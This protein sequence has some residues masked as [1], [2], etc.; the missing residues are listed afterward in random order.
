MTKWEKVVTLHRLLGRSRYSVPL[1]TILAELDNCSE[2]TFHRI[3]D[4]MRSNL[5]APLE[6]DRAHGGYRYTP[7]D[8]GP[9]ELPGFWL[10]KD[11]IEAFIC[12]DNA[13]ENL[14]EG[15]FSDLLAPLRK[16][17]EPLIRAQSTSLE[18]LRERIRIISHAGRECNQDIF[19]TVASAIMHRRCLSIT[20]HTLENRVPLQRD[21]SP[22]T[23]VRY[24]D[25]WYVDAFCHLRGEL[26]TFSL[27]RIETAGY[28]AINYRHIPKRELETFF[29]ESYG[30]FTGPAGKLAVIDFSGAA[31]REVASEN[32]HPRQKGEWL[33]TTTYRLTIPYS[34]DREL[35]MDILRWGE[36]A[37]VVGPPELREAV[38]TTIEKMREKYK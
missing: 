16:R 8:D 30:I 21:I 38:K 33:S 11:E 24:R 23:L 26:R 25:N 15:Y 34:H 31:A 2:A 5:G 37:E 28:V 29:A 6:Y 14:H 13:I 3:R 22:Q 27:S 7:S 19:R 17:F 10:T 1:K 4:F 36:L 35:I 32:W 12:I 20:H 9:Y 18:T